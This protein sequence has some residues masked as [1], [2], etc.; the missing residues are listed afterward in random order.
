MKELL[1]PQA[2]DYME[3]ARHV[4]ETAVRPVAAELDRTGDYPS[5]V[6]G[7]LRGTRSASGGSRALMRWS[8]RSR[9]AI[10]LGRA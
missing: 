4:A 3:R 10:R 8:L 7:A 9:A 1:P 2:Q 5:S 6:I